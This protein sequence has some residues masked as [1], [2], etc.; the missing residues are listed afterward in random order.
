MQLKGRYKITKQELTPTIIDRRNELSNIR[1]S[2][3]LS[4]E[5]VA[6]QN[7]YSKPSRILSEADINGSYEVKIDLPIFGIVMFDLEKIQ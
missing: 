6:F 2:Q 5:D 3:N 1:N 4:S 7:A